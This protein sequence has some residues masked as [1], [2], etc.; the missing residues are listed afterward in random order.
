[1]ISTG[2]LG[3]VFGAMYVGFGVLWI[4]IIVHIVLDARFAILPLPSERSPAT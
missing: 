4:P 2:I 3:A 1:M